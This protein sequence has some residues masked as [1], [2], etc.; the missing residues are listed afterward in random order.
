MLR[1]TACSTTGRHATSRRGNTSRSARSCPRTSPAPISAW[2]VT[3]E[4]LAPF[5]IAQ[6]PRPEGDP[7]PLPYLLD[8]AD[9]REGGLDIELEVCFSRRVC[10]RRVCRP[11]GWRCPMRGNMYWTVAQM[12]THHTCNGCNLQ[13]GDLLGTGTISG[14][15]E[16]SCGS[17][18]EATLGGKNPIA[19]ASGE[20]RRFLEDGDEVILRA[21]W[22]P[23]GLCARSAS[24]SA[25]LRSWRHHEE[26]HH[27]SGCGRT[28]P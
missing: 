23:G 18:L 24:A 14:P 21:A 15:D 9:Q 19:L 26:R 5:R 10:A 27:A 28:R 17:I 25:G 20:E 4:A 1:A 8:E 3:P 13:P 7:A 12:V 2:I 16:A 6:P 22:P 11:T